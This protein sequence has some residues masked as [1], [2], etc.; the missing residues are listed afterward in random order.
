[1]YELIKAI[2][3]ENG[4]MR[5]EVCGQKII[6]PPFKAIIESAKMLVCGK[7]VKLGA[8]AW[9]A[10]TEPH[11][12]KIQRRLPQTLVASRKQPSL[13]IEAT[14]E[15]VD[16]FGPKIRQARENFGLSHKD[17][18]KKI[19]EKAS[20]LRIIESGK[21]APDNLLIQKLQHTLKIK[22]MVPVSEPSVPAKEF[23]KVRPSATTLGDIVM[24]KK[25]DH[26]EKKR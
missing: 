9:E 14:F 17:L 6:G 21:M 15:L 16:D 24:V 12:K 10:K 4:T 19:S 26:Q 23:A 20:V 8:V 3:G 2:I 13:M 22:L 1:M 5:C 18:G 7:C 25:E 11:M